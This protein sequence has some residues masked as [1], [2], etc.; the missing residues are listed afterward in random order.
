[1]PPII[2][3]PNQ[4][5]IQETYYYNFSAQ[6]PDLDRIRF[7]IDWGDDAT[8][9]QDELIQSGDIYQIGHK[10]QDK[11]TYE[12][13]VKTI[14]EHDAE[15]EWNIIEISMPKNKQDR[16]LFSLLEQI[17]HGLFNLNGI[18]NLERIL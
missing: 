18:S 12:M 2:T 7:L 16:C 4:G 14:D 17:F 9:T 8:D 15:S 3:G 11:G 13:K 10:W 5:N 1:M 6:D